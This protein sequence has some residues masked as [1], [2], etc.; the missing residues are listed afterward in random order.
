MS[1]IVSLHIFFVAEQNS[2]RL[3]TKSLRLRVA[4]DSFF[5]IISPI[6]LEAFTIASAPFE[7]SMCFYIKALG[8]WTEELRESFKSRINGTTSAPL[9]VQIR[10]PFGAPAQHVGGYQRV[11]LVAGGVG[12]T[13][14]CAICKDLFQKINPLEEEPVN[15]NGDEGE[16]G[17]LRKAQRTVMSS[18]TEAYEQSVENFDD[19][20]GTNV[21]SIAYSLCDLFAATN[22]FNENPSQA[23]V[24]TRGVF[25]RIHDL[26]TLDHMKS[27]DENYDIE[28]SQ[29][30]RVFSPTCLNSP[31]DP[32]RRKLS[33]SMESF[34]LKSTLHMGHS[35][36]DKELRKKLTISRL[37]RVLSSLH[38]VT[39][40]LMLYML[41]LVR[42]V[43]LAYASIFDSM[44]AMSPSQSDTV[45]DKVWLTSCDVFLGFLILA[46]I[47]CTLCLELITYRGS[48]FSSKGRLTDFFLLVPISALSICIGSHAVFV[49]N[50]K[51]FL[52]PRIHFCVI[53]PLL[54]ILLV[55]RLH[56]IIGCRVLLADCYADSDYENIRAIDFIWTTP[57]EGDDDW[58]RDELSPLAN[59]THLS[60]HR[61]ITR[62]EPEAAEDGTKNA[63]GL[64]TNFG[65]V[66]F[67]PKSPAIPITVS[68]L[69]NI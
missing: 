69:R 4:C 42:V 41:M 17:G 3:L 36:V 5:D 55:Y 24:S 22:E 19:E 1:G 9:Q 27:A 64:S 40:N 66:F 38:T 30:S 61:Y 21:E 33:D 44:S 57:L 20:T 56:R 53:L 13:P 68:E 18:V 23:P 34:S 54:M 14:F 16:S 52:P 49:G 37:E 67:S 32:V 25:K 60:L 28:H 10:G 45:Y 51:F 48:Y 46:V 8:D 6:R 59:G 11:V 58:L 43:L 29:G 12:S 31:C 2:R 35:N 7:E 47:S 63:H 26:E 15:A 65:Y 62:G 50:T 39:V